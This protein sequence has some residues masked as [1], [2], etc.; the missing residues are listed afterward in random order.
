MKI[1]GDNF[2]LG[3]TIK[4]ALGRAAPYEARGYRFS[5]D[6]LGERA[7]TAADAERYFD[8]YMAAIEAIGEAK[9]PAGG[10]F[11]ALMARPSVSVKLSAI[12]PR[13]EPGKE[14]RLDR[15]LLPRLDRAGR[16]RAPAR[17]RPHRRRRGAG[18]P[19]SHARPVR[20][21]L[22]RSRARRLAGARARRAGLRQARFAGA[23]LAAAPVAAAAQA[24]PGAARQGRLLGQRD[25]VG[26]GARARRLSRV[27]A[28]GPHRRVLSRL[29]AAAAG[30][31]R[32]VLPAV[33]HPQ[34]AH[35]RVGVR[36]GGTQRVRVP[37][38]A[39]HG[40][41]AL[42]GGGRRRQARTCP[43]ASMRPSARTRTSSPIWCAACSRTAPTPPSSTAWPT[44]RRRSRRS[45]AIPSTASR[46]RARRR[47]AGC[48]APPDIYAPERVNSSGLALS[49]PAVRASLLAEV[50]AELERFYAAAPIVDGRTLTGAGGVELVL[51][52][53]DRRTA[54]ARCARPI[55]PQSRRPSQPRAPRRTPGTGSA[56]TSA[57][58]SSTAPPTSTSATACA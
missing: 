6:M 1:L 27:H 20:R 16:G 55:Q 4:E 54:S 48:P 45:C 15:E 8:R 28:Q 3:R 56:A 18:P 10:D 9:G 38:P 30:R 17:D 29:R 37:A 41:G 39:R 36:G 22:L 32:R 5:Y 25:Q 43:A 40:R 44:R 42:R 14:A 47:R 51:S 13:F 50:A 49:E 57:R 33:R 52:P 7:K 11:H 23:A 34:R 12:H 24:D 46:A 53:H 31:S 2:V 21:R 35:D 19:R 26:A 58:A